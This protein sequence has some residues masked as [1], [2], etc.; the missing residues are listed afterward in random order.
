MF[1]VTFALVDSLMQGPM[2]DFYADYC[3][4]ALTTASA[5]ARLA[6]KLPETSVDEAYTS[7]L[8]ADV[9]ALFLAQLESRRYQHVYESALLGSELICEEQS[10]FGFD[11]AQLGARLLSQWE[12][13]ESVVD[14]VCHHHTESTKPQ[15]LRDTVFAGNLLADLLAGPDACKLQQVTRFLYERLHTASGDLVELTAD[16]MNE[17]NEG[18]HLFGG[19]QHDLSNPDNLLARVQELIEAAEVT[20]AS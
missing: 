2:T 20:V 17:V 5:A 7:G 16:C 9:G 1:A 18:A 4:R 8:L 3:L 12:L 10:T 13:P 19:V 15:P 11:H 6:E 14:A